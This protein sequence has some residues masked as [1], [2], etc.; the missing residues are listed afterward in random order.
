MNCDVILIDG[1]YVVAVIMALPLRALHRAAD[2]IERYV[3]RMGMAL[4]EG[5]I[6]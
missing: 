5:H 1:R 3:E 6:I 2:W 4:Q